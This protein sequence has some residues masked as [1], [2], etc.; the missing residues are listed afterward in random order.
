MPPSDFETIY[1]PGQ[2]EITAVLSE[3]AWTQGV[4]PNCPIDSG[5]YD[6][7]DTTTGISADILGW[8]AYDLAGWQAFD[9][10]YER[11][12][13]T[14]TLFGSGPCRFGCSGN[15]FFEKFGRLE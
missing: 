15:G 7:S 2:T 4:G 13:T 12:Q 3:N 5:Q 1:K 11:N 8:V 6:F 10:S 9:S 14:V